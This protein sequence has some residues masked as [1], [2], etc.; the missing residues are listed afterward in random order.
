MIWS[1][2]PCT[3]VIS[4]RTNMWVESQ[5]NLSNLKS[6][7]MF[8]FRLMLYVWSGILLTLLTW[9]EFLHLIPDGLQISNMFNLG[10]ELLQLLWVQE[11]QKSPVNYLGFRNFIWCHTYLVWMNKILAF[12]AFPQNG[13]HLSDLTIFHKYI[14]FW[15]LWQLQ[16]QILWFV[17]ASL[18]GSAQKFR[19]AEKY[20]SLSFS[21]EQTSSVALPRK[22]PL[23]H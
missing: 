9:L 16:Q 1:G 21:S 12:K 10:V 17:V 4:L 22:T 18:F 14:I 19:V 2:W 20:G 13:T 3:V 23:S 6:S 7:D 8:G 11:T 5:M 15:D